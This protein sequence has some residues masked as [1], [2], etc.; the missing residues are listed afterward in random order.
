LLLQTIDDSQDGFV[1]S[2][3][4]IIMTGIGDDNIRVG[5]GRNIGGFVDGL[6]KLGDIGAL[7]GRNGD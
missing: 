5:E 3:Q 7:F 4:G 6:L 2:D 1:G